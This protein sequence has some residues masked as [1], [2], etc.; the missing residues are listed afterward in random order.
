MKSFTYVL[1][2]NDVSAIA[3]AT[4][5]SQTAMYLGGGTNLL[6]LMK[7]GVKKPEILIGVDA[8]P[9]SKIETVQR[10]EGKFLSIGAMVKNSDLAYHPEVKKRYPVLSEALLSGA[11]AQLRNMATVGGNLLQ[12]TR[13]PYYNDVVFPCNKRNPGSGCPAIEGFNRQLAILGT[14]DQCIAS[15][16]SDM[17][18][19]LAAIDPVI[20]VRGKNGERSIA[21]KDF[22]LL[23]GATPEREFALLPGELITSVDLP[24]IP[25]AARSR[26]L[27][28]RDRASY[29]FALVSV[30]VI[31]DM[32][33]NTIRDARIAL[34]GVGTKPWR[35][36]AAEQGIRGASISESTAER[37]ASEL[38]KGA[39]GYSHNAFKIELAKC[40]I[41]RAF[42][43]TAEVRV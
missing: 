5:N 41:L 36:L 14:S 30:A 25:W 8:L 4:M 29:E 13:C 16:P 26:Y 31:L 2:K 21:F 7:L 39:R 43:E 3:S 23:P 22:H 27:K 10:P 17:N 19:A 6:D 34:G 24:E 28:I 9:F 11:S 42:R 32:D 12:R 40:A 33:G 38:L 1:P 35:V 18:V 20:R 37:A 15:N